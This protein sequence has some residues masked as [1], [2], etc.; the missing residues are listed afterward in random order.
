MAD[1]DSLQTATYRILDASANRAGEGL[2]TLEEVARFRLNDAELTARLKSM[3]H[4]LTAALGRLPRASL[5]AARD[6]E[7]DV[8]TEIQAAAEYQRAG[9][10]GV[11]AAAAARIQQS[12]RVLEEN[13]KTIDL[14][15]AAEI[16]Q[17]RYRSYPLAAQL[18]LSLDRNDRLVRLAQSKLYALVDAGPSE[19]AFAETVSQ[20]LKGGVDV[21]QLRDRRVDDRT[22]LARAKVAAAI[23]RD[24]D[25]L[26]IV[27]DRVDLAV[28]AEADGVHV[29]QQ[30]LP[31]VDARRI[32]GP[33]RL[34][35]LS[36][37]SIEQAREAVA[38]G[39]DY[40]GCGPVFAGHTKDFDRY[41]GTDL[42]SQVAAEIRLPAFA[43]G[44]IDA[45]NVD[46]VIDAGF[47][48]IA[49]TGALRDADDPLAAARD[50]S[51]RLGDGR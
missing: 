1:E 2:R 6:T 23:A 7:G 49:V 17:I 22:L 29:G 19:Q 21:I 5:L 12:L 4:D 13:A 44:G 20:L 15:A 50:L 45:S 40:I 11:V 28:A 46:Q 35:G 41:V 8:G 31:V 36:T 39:A 26:F 51:E 14:V 24:A 30:E 32:L 38:V 10:L 27:N 33:Q 47:R 25:K 43:I 37:H 3:R 18:E 9:T 42:L 48:R 34:I 16:E